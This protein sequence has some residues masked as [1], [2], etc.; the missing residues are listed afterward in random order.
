MAKSTIT[1]YHDEMLDLIGIGIGPFNL[2]LAAMLDKTPGIK[3]LFLEKKPRFDWHPGLLLE[4]TTLQVPFLAD[5]VTM[6]DPTSPY[7]FLNYLKEH[8]RLYHFY[9]LER[10]L[11]PRKEYNHY[12]Q[13][14]AGQLDHCLFGRTVTQIEFVQGGTE[15]HFRIKVREEST[16]ATHVYR[17]K[18]LVLGGGSVPFVHPNFADLPKEDVFHSAEFLE[19]RDRCRQADSITVIG[20]GQSAAEVFLA[21]LQEQETHRYRLD[22]LTRSSGFFPM[23]YSKLGLEHFSPDYTRY[24]Y[25]LPPEKRD[26]RLKKQDL[27]YKGI[28]ARTIADIYDLLYERTVSK[29]QINVRL[30]SQAEIQEIAPFQADGKQKYRLSCT[31]VEE[32]KPFTHESEVVILATGYQHQI[33]ECL[34][35]ISPHIKW[36]EQGRYTISNDYRIQLTVPTDCTLFVQNGELHTHGVGAPD[37]GLGAYRNSVIINTLVGKT[38]YPVHPRNVFQQFGVSTPTMESHTTL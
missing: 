13:W 17:A 5:V 4:G 10:F 32:G 15:D 35:G 25:S 2:G 34:S 19:R 38:V 6:A 23:E 12:C 21:L 36:D 29:K 8:Q 18:N 20:S 1:I 30:L 33:P 7:S 27:L 28:S 11:I 22:W 37:L 26:R 3:A 14:V 16:S 24:F 9:F 31:H